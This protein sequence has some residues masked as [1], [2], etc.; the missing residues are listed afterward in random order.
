V[1]PVPGDKSN[2][3][4]SFLEINQPTGTALDSIK[5]VMPFY[6][7]ALDKASQSKN[8][9]LPNSLLKGLTEYQKKYGKAVML[10]E[11][12]IKRKFL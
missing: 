6:L 10:S 12:K 3:W 1:F 7:N 4:V 8:Y 2:K 9:E 11:S 5:N